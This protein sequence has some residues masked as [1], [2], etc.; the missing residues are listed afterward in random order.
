[1]KRFPA[2]SCKF[3]YFVPTLFVGY[4]VVL[5]AI[6]CWRHFMGG[7]ILGPVAAVA[8][9]PFLFYA[10]ATMISTFS[11]NPCKWIVTEMGVFLSHVWYGV[12]FMRGLCASKAPCEFIGK[13]HA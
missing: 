1:M 13:D 12:Q 4:L 2:T 11:F 3:S 10:A 6:F 5:A 9:S 7:G 8:A